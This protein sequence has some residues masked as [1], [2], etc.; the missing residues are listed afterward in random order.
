MTMSTDQRPDPHLTALMEAVPDVIYFKDREGRHILVNQAMEEISGLP[1]EEITGKRDGDLLPPELAAAC[2]E[3]DRRVLEE[4]ETVRTEEV[5]PTPEGDRIYD[6][7]KTPLRGGDGT[8]TGLVG[9]SR[10]ITAQKKAEEKVVQ[11]EAMFRGIFEGADDGII[12][13]GITPDHR[14]GR[15]LE[16][17]SRLTETLGYTREELVGRS[18]TE[19]IAPESP[20]TSARIREDLMTEGR[21]RF[22]AGMVD[23]DGRTIPVEVSTNLVT[24]GDGLRCVTIVRDI[25]ERRELERLQQEA[26]AT[27]N[28]NLEQLAT[29]NDQIRNPLAVI[30]G[31]ADMVGGEEGDRIIDMAATIDR[32]I[33]RLDQGWLE[34]KKVR[35][36]LHRYYAD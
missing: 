9:I 36:F 11:S 10:E 15:I 16:V 8:I 31:Y 19:I 35:D 6:T 22:E 23:R 13:H 26:F 20:E 29:L 5:M 27:I 32:I 33:T 14:P 24:G 28:R 30:V 1:R 34:S 17:N 4:G 12:I 25:T 18:M 2:R 21:S 3:S 7:I